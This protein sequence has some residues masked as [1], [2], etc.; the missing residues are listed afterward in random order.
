MCG[1]VNQG[2]PLHR[3]L[4]RGRSPF[5]RVKAGGMPVLPQARGEAQRRSFW[6]SPVPCPQEHGL[7]LR[8]FDSGEPRETLDA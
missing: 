7:Q 6:R 8:A 2:G 1:C 3:R 5:G 4:P